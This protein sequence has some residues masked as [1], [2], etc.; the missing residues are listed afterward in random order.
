MESPNFNA[1]VSFF[2]TDLF[3]CSSL[4]GQN[5]SV[6]EKIKL[7]HVIELIATHMHMALSWMAYNF[8]V[9]KVLAIYS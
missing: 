3:C 2:R 1:T 5:F 6:L 8:V 4:V 7:D 9:R